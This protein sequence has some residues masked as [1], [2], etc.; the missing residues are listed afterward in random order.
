MEDLNIPAGAEQTASP[1]YCATPV[2]EEEGKILRGILDS[3]GL[4]S[5]PVSAYPLTFRGAQR[6]RGG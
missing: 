2:S 4:R 3:Y 1:T 5:C 6:L